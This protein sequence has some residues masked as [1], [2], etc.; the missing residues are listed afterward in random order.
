MEIAYLS[1]TRE[2]RRRISHI[3]RELNVKLS[4]I[5]RRVNIEGAPLD[6][7][8]ALQFFEAMNFGFSVDKSLLLC[9]EDFVFRKV[10]IKSHTR[11]KLKDIRARLI[12]THGKTR[13]TMTE[14]SGCE[15]IIGESEVGI[16]GEVE[17][18][19]NVER[20]VIH[21]IEG[22]KQGNMY[23]YLER[24]N[25]ERKSHEDYQ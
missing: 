5:G 23:K 13:K 17:E 25:R 15:I 12:G 21:L 18:V 24:M 19:E 14:I 22:A 16:I 2:V 6:E 20:A 3:S 7:Y 11:R 10:K 4:L 9:K 8:T 1:K